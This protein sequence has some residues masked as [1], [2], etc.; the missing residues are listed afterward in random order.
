MTPFNQSR[1]YADYHAHLSIHMQNEERC[2]DSNIIRNHLMVAECGKWD[3]KWLGGY[4]MTGLVLQNIFWLKY[5][6]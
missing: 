2:C 4:E 5:G 1:E 6:Q 3:N